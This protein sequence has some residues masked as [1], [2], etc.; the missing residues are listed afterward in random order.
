MESPLVIKDN[1]KLNNTLSNDS[2]NIYTKL[3]SYDDAYYNYL[4]CLENH[5]KVADVDTKQVQ[6]NANSNYVYDANSCIP[7][8]STTLIN[9]INQ[10]KK[11]MGKLPLN[12][13]KPESYND[14]LDQYQQMVEL[15]TQLDSRLNDL[16]NLKGSIPMEIQRETDSTLYATITW[17]ILATCVIYMIFIVE[18]E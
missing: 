2:V 3:K 14:L 11:D 10:L 15:R 12:N 5:P 17:T 9:E 13:Q 16:Y 6:R 18:G 8:D 4:T 7:P 1:T